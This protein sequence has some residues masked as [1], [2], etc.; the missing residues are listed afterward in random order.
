VEGH[1]EGHVRDDGRV[2][3]GM[4]MGM[5]GMGDWRKGMPMGMFVLRQ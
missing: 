4:L 3:K 1:A 5:L 2:A